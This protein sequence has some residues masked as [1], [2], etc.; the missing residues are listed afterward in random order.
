M[1][2]LAIRGRNLASLAGDFVIDFE[3]EPLASAGIFVIT[4]PTGAG[5]S[6]LLDAMSLALFDEIPRL[7][8]ASRG[9]IG[10]D[11][12]G[13]GTGDARSILRHGC[14]E[15]FA[16]V[17]F[18]ARDGHRYRSRWSV[19]RAR[20]RADGAL[21]NVTLAF[22]R[23]DTGEAIGGTRTETK[24]AIREVVGLS[25]D[26][27][28]RAVVLAQ[29]EFEAFIRAKPH[30]R[31]DL[32]EKLTGSD[33]YT[34][35]G[36]TA[37]A[38]ASEVRARQQ[39]IEDRIAAQQGL[40]DAAR[41]Q[42]EK[43]LVEASATKVAASAARDGFLAAE[44]WEARRRELTLAIASARGNLD[45][46]QADKTAAEPRRQALAHRRRAFALAP[47][48]TIMAA[49]DVALTKAEAS[50]ADAKG[51]ADR[52]VTALAE[53][54]NNE[55]AANDAA[56][57]TT[58]AAKTVAP[59]IETARALDQT[60]LTASKAVS[61]AGEALEDL[62]ADND[63]AAASAAAAR[64]TL[65]NTTADLAA[66]CEWLQANTAGEALAREEVALVRNLGGIAPLR[67]RIAALAGRAST[68]TE[69][70]TDAATALSSAKESVDAAAIALR[71]AE[72]AVLDSEA[73]LPKAGSAKGLET[74][75]DTLVQ[76]RAHH[77]QFGLLALRAAELD[78]NL[79]R[80]RGQVEQVKLERTERET[81]RAVLVAE[82]P[83][84]EARHD[85]AA[86]ACALSAAAA[87]EAAQH[88]RSGLVAGE[89]CPV[90]GATEHRESALDALLGD[91]ALAA[92]ARKEELH[93]SL[94][95]MRQRETVLAT[96]IKERAD[97]EIS[98]GADATALTLQI[99]EA[100]QT[101]D[102]ARA[103]LAAAVQSIGLDPS[104]HAALGEAIVAQL[105]ATDARRTKLREATDALEA[106][107]E[108]ERTAR[109]AL[110][111]AR[112]GVSTT[113]E[114]WHTAKR[115]SEELS[116]ELT[117]AQ[118]DHDRLA[119]AIDTLVGDAVDWR[120]LPDAPTW[121]ATQAAAWRKHNAARHAE[122][123]ALPDLRAS[124][125]TAQSRA[126]AALEKFAIA[127]TRHGELAAQLAK[128]RAARATLLDGET[129]AVVTTRMHSAR[130]AVDAA[131]AAARE[132]VGSAKVNLATT[133]ANKAK[134]E[135]AVSEARTDRDAKRDLLH[136]E[137]AATGLALAEV[138]SAATSGEM[139]LQAEQDALNALELALAGAVSALTERE[140]DLTAHDA[141]DPPALLGPDLNAALEA[142]RAAAEAAD[143]A[144]RSIQV[145]LLNDDRVR[146]AT[147]A[148][149]AELAEKRQT[150]LVWEKLSELIG[151][152]EGKNFRNFA[153]GI[154]LDLLL[155]QANVRLADLKPRYSLERGLGGEML[156]QVVD[157]DMAGEV[158]GLHNLSGG[159]RFLVSLA[160][161]LGLAEMSTTR[162]VRIESLFIDEGFGA[163]DPQSLGQAIAVLE[164]LHANG[165]RVGVISHVEELKERIPV[166]IEVTPKSR[167]QSEINIMVD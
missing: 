116:R 88:L 44:R 85:E 27:F 33:I 30:E 94:G 106:T 113:Q 68:A 151:D 132:T 51:A 41:D 34:R 62:R 24:Q 110:D 147:A 56:Q 109:I 66:H 96:E 76:L 112:T 102:S 141:L 101:L 119:M 21:Q 86:R 142:A 130:E 95:A 135:Y 40:G 155:E 58:A 74:A 65:E 158:R 67:E 60:I 124:D 104:N 92:T 1:R 39:A 153:Q 148:L 14:G 149:R 52:A 99:V 144:V 163:L 78:E 139:V 48:W 64:A 35:L 38:R 7:S 42:Q 162:G 37:F 32:L 18:Q 82:L 81:A 129:V 90:C 118:A 159:E 10:G 22:E 20:E 59:A 140:K 91:A 156:I 70:T 73:S 146:E 5:K 71:G 150:G 157:H 50:L 105:A 47:A 55:V 145:V 16:E 122:E 143:E 108:T 133:A 93:A 80:L 123:S 89:P 26:Q 72:K 83:T 165:R 117:S 77:E 98:L 23:L 4:G 29:G 69:A 54:R 61:D 28:S 36:K 3:A 8:A 126:E 121:V 152:R 137:L 103:D 166:K 164:H 53:A 100:S 49:A 136:S 84:M 46:A 127:Q 31:A 43:A 9:Q 120:L 167:G 79:T 134:D 11:G 114:A 25:A 63:A 128:H 107:R 57:A 75:R 138:E 154:T 161:A 6:T 19:R 125:A 12:T 87:D 160:L 111:V 13:I 15:G 97:R 2:I 45:K 17:D 131:L 115:Q